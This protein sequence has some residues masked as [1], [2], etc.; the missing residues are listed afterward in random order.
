MLRLL[1]SLVGPTNRR[2]SPRYATYEARISLQWWEGGLAHETTAL[3]LNIG[4]GGALLRA[5]HPPPLHQPIR[6]HLE[7][8]E[9]AD[10][11]DARVVRLCGL[12]EVGVTFRDVC[13][14]SF[15]ALTTCT[16]RVERDATTPLE[17]WRPRP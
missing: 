2:A 1:T 9:R 3:L 15:L 12:H 6:V 10:W 5:D 13:P 16:G 7:R 14:K 4:D 17:L 11:V 8:P